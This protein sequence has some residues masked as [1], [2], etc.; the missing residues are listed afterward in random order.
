MALAGTVSFIGGFGVAAVE[1]AMVLKKIPTLTIRKLMV[2]LNALGNSA[3]LM[4]FGYAKTPQGAAMAFTAA[5]L[6][7]CLQVRTSPEP[8]EPS[9]D[10]LQLRLRQS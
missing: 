2:V 4:W 9:P 5:E 10:L 8:S 1:S 7:A 3:S 6:C